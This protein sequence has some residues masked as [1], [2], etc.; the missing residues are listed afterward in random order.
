MFGVNHG[1]A[2][3]LQV[4]HRRRAPHRAGHACRA[5][6]LPTMAFVHAVSATQGGPTGYRA[7]FSCAQV[8]ATRRSFAV[9]ATA[10]RSTASAPVPGRLGDERSSRPDG[11]TR[12]SLRARPEVMTIGAAPLL[13]QQSTDEEERERS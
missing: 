2:R 12:R 5:T 9:A 3:N 6:I 7:V 8:A 4:L 1:A 11:A 10:V 13:G